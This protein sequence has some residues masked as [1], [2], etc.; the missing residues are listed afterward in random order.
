MDGERVLS[1]DAFRGTAV[2]AMLIAGN[3]GNA[4]AVY[5]NLQP[6]VWHG[7]TP[8]D[9]LFPFFLVCAGVVIPFSLGRRRRAG[10]AES[11]LIG[12]ILKR[13]AG[14]FLLGL[15]LNF[16]PAFDCSAV[17]IPGILQRIALCYSAGALLGLKTKP[18]ARV[19][20]SAVLP[21]V[22]AAL[23]FLVPV[24]GHGAGILEPDGNLPGYLD[25]LIF[26]RH[27]LKPGFD[28]EGLLSTLPAVAVLLIGTLLGDWL[29]TPRTMVRKT[30]GVFSAGLPLTAAGLLLHP[31]LPINRPLWTPAFAFLGAGLALIVFGLYYYLIEAL[32]WKRWSWPFRVLGAN[33]ITVFAGSVLLEKILRLIT[34]SSGGV[35][36]DAV[37]FIHERILG[38]LAA[39]VPGR[40]I[41]AV[42][43]ALLWIG[44][45]APLYRHR[46][47]IRI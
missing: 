32:Q 1:I 45:T 23:I 24:P 3:P 30:L 8:A 17:R 40:L 47:S 21:A 34:V 7:W 31:V 9:L 43:A 37:V 20:L 38:P 6:A 13:S 46:L 16:F 15:F 4:H 22:Y 33:S 27:L 14:L 5:S 25:N 36:L 18:S 35:R 11:A 39:P 19:V 2:A 12:Q 28:S 29:R 41:Y 42:L 44:L 10:I 26:G